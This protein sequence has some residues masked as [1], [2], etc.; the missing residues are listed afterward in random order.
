MSELRENRQV[1]RDQLKKPMKE[2]R[3]KGFGQGQ[4]GSSLPTPPSRSCFSSPRLE[5]P[6]SFY[7]AQEPS[8]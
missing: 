7:I 2:L 4:Q 8:R 6:N 3:K 5:L 1:L